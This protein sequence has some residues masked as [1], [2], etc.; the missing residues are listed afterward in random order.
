MKS[1]SAVQLGQPE[2]HD[3][4]LAAL[5][6]HDVGALDVPVND[7]LLMGFFQALRDLDRDIESFFERKRA[8][9]DLLPEVFPLDI[10]H[11]DERLAFAFIDFMDRADVRVGQRGGR[12]GLLNKSLPGFRI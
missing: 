4:G 8:S 1:R 7:P 5:G 12:A 2:I 6:D 9:S 11:D 10:L 3:L